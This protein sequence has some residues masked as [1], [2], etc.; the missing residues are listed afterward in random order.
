M[1]LRILFI[2]LVLVVWL[3]SA[4]DESPG[5]FLKVAKNVP[6]LG[7]RSNNEYDNFFLKASKS[8]PRIGRSNFVSTTHAA[9]KT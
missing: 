1:F 8:V 7:R 4:T 2:N 9:E 6:R 3:G 5:F